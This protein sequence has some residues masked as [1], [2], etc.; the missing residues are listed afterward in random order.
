MANLVP[1]YPLE[2]KGARV[3]CLPCHRPLGGGTGIWSQVRWHL[4]GGRGKG[5]PVGRVGVLVVGR[6]RSG[7]GSSGCE[8]VWFPG[9]DSLPPQGLRR[10]V[11]ELPL[12]QG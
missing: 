12:C 7:V 3:A 8:L 9:A 6:E 10:R 5:E 11:P 2:G 4:F 1:T